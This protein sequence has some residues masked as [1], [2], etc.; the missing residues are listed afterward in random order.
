MRRARP[1]VNAGIVLGPYRSLRSFPLE[2]ARNTQSS[3][4]VK[5]QKTDRS[6][7]SASECR[8]NLA[9]WP[10]C[11]CGSSCK[12]RARRGVAMR[13][14]AELVRA[15]APYAREDRARTWRLLAVAG[16]VYL[17]AI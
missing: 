4:H 7:R 15:T 2:R 3:C 9:R 6:V 17:G 10:L 1:R 12:A 5:S 16:G 13:K 8:Q 14:G 11:T